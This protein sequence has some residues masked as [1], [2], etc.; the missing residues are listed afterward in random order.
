MLEILLQSVVCKGK[1]SLRIS[2]K[3]NVIDPLRN[4]KTM[5]GKIKREFR[6]IIV[7]IK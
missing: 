7:E 5:K 1:V 2:P 3:G 6:F 4:L